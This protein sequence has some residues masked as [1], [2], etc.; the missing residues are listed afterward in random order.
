MK[1]K[2]SVSLEKSVALAL[3][4]VIGRRGSR[5]AAIELAVRE[6]LERRSQRSRD[7]RDIATINRNASRLNREAEDV[8]TYQAKP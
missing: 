5:S 4:R 7:A 3:D 6:F 1:V 2:T 8:L